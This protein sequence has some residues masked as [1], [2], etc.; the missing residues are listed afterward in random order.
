MDGFRSA[1]LGKPWNFETLFISTAATF[2]LLA[3]GAMYFRSTERR[4]ADIA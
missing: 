3:I 2:V 1:I 4:F